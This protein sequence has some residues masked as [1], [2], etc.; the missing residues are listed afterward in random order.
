MRYGTSQF[1]FEIQEKYKRRK[2]RK[3]CA[4]WSAPKC[5]LAHFLL[6]TYW[7]GRSSQR[8]WEDGASLCPALQCS[9]RICLQ[10]IYVFMYLCWYL[11]QIHVCI[12]L[13]GGKFCNLYFVFVF[14]LKVYLSAGRNCFQMFEIDNI[15]K[16]AVCQN[17]HK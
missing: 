17:I 5:F 2:I 15:N 7:R 8:E 9:R 10:F 13:Q 11:T 3:I 1:F 6:L 4:K 16:D 12:C 14:H